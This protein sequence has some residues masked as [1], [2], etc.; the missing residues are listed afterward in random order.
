M[1]ILLK[2]LSGHSVASRNCRIRVSF[3]DSELDPA[4]ALL[5]LA[6]QARKRAGPDAGIVPV[7]DE[8]RVFTVT[9]RECEIRSESCPVRSASAGTVDTARSHVRHPHAVLGNCCLVI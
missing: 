5:P 4:A 2:I 8:A 9:W 7:S 6:C 1:L 3:L